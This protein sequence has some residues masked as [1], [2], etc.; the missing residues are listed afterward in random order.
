[1]KPILHQRKSKAD[2]WCHSLQAGA[3]LVSQPPMPDY[4]INDTF[5]LRL[6]KKPSLR[7]LASLILARFEHS[8]DVV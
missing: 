4:Q 8:G 5:N 3:Q 1:V 2:A 7:N 6:F